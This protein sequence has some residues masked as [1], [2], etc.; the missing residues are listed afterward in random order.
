MS[1]AMIFTNA[2]FDG[3][4]MA[5]LVSRV[6]PP[7]TDQLRYAELLSALLKADELRRAEQ[8]S[9]SA[10]RIAMFGLCCGALVLIICMGLYV[11]FI[12]HAHRMLAAIVLFVWI[13]TLAG[14]FLVG[15]SHHKLADDCLIRF[16]EQ[17]Q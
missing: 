15:L 6:P 10:F 3:F 14:S 4:T 11:Y 13:S 8:A 7:W 16:P 2:F 17:N 12:C 5:G 1:N 9:L